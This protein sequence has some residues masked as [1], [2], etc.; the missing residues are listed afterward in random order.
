MGLIV[1]GREV[2]NRETLAAHAA[3]VLCL[4]HGIKLKKWRHIPGEL[5]ETNHKTAI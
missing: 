4:A 2:H 1:R 5:R 3:P